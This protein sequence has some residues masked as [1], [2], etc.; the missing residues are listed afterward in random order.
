MQATKTTA[1]SANSAGQ[2]E[3][4]LTLAAMDLNGGVLPANVAATQDKLSDWAEFSDDQFEFD[5][6]GRWS[7][8]DDF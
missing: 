1:I 4:V 6:P 3:V 7:A 2:V 5:A 8:L